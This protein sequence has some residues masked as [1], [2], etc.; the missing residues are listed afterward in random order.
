M[1]P[2]RLKCILLTIEA[3][4]VEKC[5]TATDKTFKNKTH[6]PSWQFEYGCGPLADMITWLKMIMVRVRAI[7]Y[8]SRLSA[9]TFY[10]LI[11][12]SAE[13]EI[14]LIGIFY[15]QYM[16]EIA[17]W[18]RSNNTLYNKRKQTFRVYKQV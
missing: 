18:P 5:Q 12:L 16:S 3:V 8:Q 17:D 4:N 9:S 6:P 7:G 2:E 1:C 15:G 13:E 10:N 14:G 11:L